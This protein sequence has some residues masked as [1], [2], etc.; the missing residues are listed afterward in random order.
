MAGTPN[1]TLRLS[2]RPENVLLVRQAINGL[3]D[4]LGLD[5]LDLNDINTAVTEACNNV[6]LHAYDG[7]EG[8]LE[9]D[10]CLGADDLEVSVRDSGRGIAPSAQP[11]GPVDGGIGLPVMHALASDVQLHDRD[12]SGTDVEMRFALTGILSAA[13]PALYYLRTFKRALNADIGANQANGSPDPTLRMDLMKKLNLGGAL[14]ELP[15]A[16]GVFYLLAGGEKRW[17]VG[18]ACMSIALRLS[19]RPFT[20]VR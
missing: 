15:L 17:F 3:A 11:D 7:G 1:V 16:L 6:V 14:S 19:Y 8:P 9:V 12:G 4:A 18:A 20:G 10:L 2:N 5:P 13:I